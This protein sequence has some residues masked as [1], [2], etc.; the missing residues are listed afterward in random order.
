MLPSRPPPPRSTVSTLSTHARTWRRCEAHSLFPQGPRA[1]RE[2][3][4]AHLA[5]GSA[6][7]TGTGQ[8][9]PP[10]QFC[11]ETL[12][13]HSHSHVVCRAFSHTRAESLNR[14]HGPESL[15]YLPVTSFAVSV[16][17]SDLVLRRLVTKKIAEK[18]KQSTK[19]SFII[20]SGQQS[21]LG[22]QTWRP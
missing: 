3:C 19:V 14:L 16:L 15:K 22:S 4:S 13:Q 11:S 12:R 20:I 8:G 5:L 2:Q 18:S 9:V 10:A 7:R 6:V 1:A 17:S 21:Y